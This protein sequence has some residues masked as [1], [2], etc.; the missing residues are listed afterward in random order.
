MA[1]YRTDILAWYY[2]P[3]SSG[4]MEGTKNKSKTLKRQAYGYRDQ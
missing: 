3:L 2:Q 4:P 1:M